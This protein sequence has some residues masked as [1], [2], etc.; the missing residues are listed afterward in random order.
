MTEIFELELGQKRDV[1]I[2]KTQLKLTTY[3]F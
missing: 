1:A 3:W 2:M